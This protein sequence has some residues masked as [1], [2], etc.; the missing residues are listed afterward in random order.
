M[1]R[2]KGLYW[3]RNWPGQHMWKLQARPNGRAVVLLQTGTEGDQ[4]G[5]SRHLLNWKAWAVFYHQGDMEAKG[6]SKK[7]EKEVS[8]SQLA[9]APHMRAWSG[10]DHWADNTLCSFLLPVRGQHFQVLTS[11]LQRKMLEWLSVHLKAITQSPSMGSC[12]CLCLSE[13]PK[14]WTCRKSAHSPAGESKS[15]SLR[16][17]VF[18]LDELRRRSIT[19]LDTKE[20]DKKVRAYPFMKCVIL[21]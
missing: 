17:P 3:W 16:I 1:T 9:I 4:P 15:H 11:S 21:V 13:D 18:G 12:T 5:G 20:S 14:D 6:D 8:Q 7:P 19:A 10:Q 2:W